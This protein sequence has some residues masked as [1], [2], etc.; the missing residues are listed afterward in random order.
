MDYDYIDKNIETKP[1][2]T[3]SKILKH[4]INLLAVKKDKPQIFGSNKYRLY[5]YPGDVDLIEEVKTNSLEKTTRLFSKKIKEIVKNI[6]KEKNTFLSDIKM[7]LD[8]IYKIKIGYCENGIFYINNNAKEEIEIL[9]DFNL[10]ESKDYEY[11][12]NIFSKRVGSQ[13]EFDLTFKVIRKYFVLRWSAKEIINGVKKLKGNRIIKLEDAIKQ[14][15]LIKIDKIT[16]Y[17]GRFVEITN[18]YLL[19]YEINNKTYDITF[20][21]D[22][23]L[24]KLNIQQLYYS[25]LN[26]SPF[27]M[28]KRMYSYCRLKYIK[29]LK[30]DN[31]YG[32][33]LKKIIPILSGNI[34]LLSQIKSDLNILQTI[35]KTNGYI[36][37][38]NI[39]TQ[40][41][42]TKNRLST[43]VEI[44]LNELNQ[45]IK[46]IDNVINSKNNDERLKLMD[47]LDE[48]YSK[49]INYHTI[50]YLNKVFL[51]P[52]PKILLPDYYTIQLYWPSGELYTK[53]TINPYKNVIRKPNDDPVKFFDESINFEKN[54]K[55]KEY[56]DNGEYI[57]KLRVIND[58]LNQ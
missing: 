31:I 37:V 42:E 11:L 51:N 23:E 17:N 41:D 10:L 33:I 57:S 52:P 49:I 9:N 58:I 38:K 8:E 6:N 53:Q 20:N 18:I 16:L 54:I 19:Q 28:V 32:N 12:I 2:D 56:D 7:G 26:Y 44:N 22:G 45:L 29:S 24:I 27:K 1:D 39:N 47:L 4:E 14:N 5:K 36:E 35:S 43:V 34:S 30:K 55:E 15:S 48:K 3:M 50:S 21:G 13:D 40:L 46:I 25:N